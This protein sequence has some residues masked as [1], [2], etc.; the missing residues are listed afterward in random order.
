MRGAHRTSNTRRS[1]RCP[2]KH[3]SQNAYVDGRAAHA[4]GDGAAGAGVRSAHIKNLKSRAEKR[5]SII[6]RGLRRVRARV[7]ARIKNG[8][9]GG[10][11]DGGD[12]DGDG[13]EDVDEVMEDV[14]EQG[15]AGEGGEP[16]EVD[17][18]VSVDADVV[19]VNAN[20]VKVN[21]NANTVD[22][23]VKDEPTTVVPATD[24]G[25]PD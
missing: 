2:C 12:D 6:S 25:V 18:G 15:G 7:L 10:G 4:E 9:D 14:E 22:V 17:N 1:P 5:Q 8:D 19:N 20:A 13:E 16:P 3:C 11:D 23:T 24:H 21:V